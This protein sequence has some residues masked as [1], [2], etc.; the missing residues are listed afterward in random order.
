MGLKA[1]LKGATADSTSQAALPRRVN[2]NNDAES[3]TSLHSE[4]MPFSTRYPTRPDERS[5]TSSDGLAGRHE[6]LKRGG[7]AS[8]ETLR[9]LFGGCGKY[10]IWSRGV[11]EFVEAWN[12]LRRECSMAGAS[13]LVVTVVVMM[14][15]MSKRELELEWLLL[16]ESHSGTK[17]V[18][19]QEQCWIEPMPID[20]M[21]AFI[22][23][24]SNKAGT[25]TLCPAKRLRAPI[26]SL[27][28]RRVPQCLALL[29]NPACPTHPALRQREK[30]RSVAL[31]DLLAR[32]KD[33]TWQF[34]VNALTERTGFP[35]IA[36]TEI[37]AYAH[38]V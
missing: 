16:R 21:A 26:L 31:R 11:I 34:F 30:H 37:V 20:G 7:M 4:A 27:E 38:G 23:L 15:L 17:V 28:S 19:A 8:T 36:K 24:A 18:P 9:D 25:I 14:M 5:E 1:D 12:I 2:A 6:P 32:N 29:L 22:D 33:E 3:N 35:S 13:S 10:Q